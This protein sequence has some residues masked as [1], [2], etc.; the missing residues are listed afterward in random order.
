LPQSPPECM[1]EDVW[2]MGLVFYE[3]LTGRFPFT[4]DNKAEIYNNVREKPV[5]TNFPEFVSEPL[6][7]LVLGMLEKDHTKRLVSQEVTDRL[8]RI[9]DGAEDFIPPRVLG[10]RPQPEP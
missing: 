2:A 5:D 8:R 9:C 6:K 7:D 4:G 1:A 3:I 10:K